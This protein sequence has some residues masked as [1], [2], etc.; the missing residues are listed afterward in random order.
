MSAFRIVPKQSIKSLPQR[1]KLGS[2]CAFRCAQN[3]EP[4]RGG[5][6][7]GR[8]GSW[9]L[10]IL[11]VPA[12]GVCSQCKDKVQELIDTKGMVPVP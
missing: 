8:S 3:S 6:R 12:I 11:G 9:V 1:F 4:G 2:H 10:L 7:G 5:A